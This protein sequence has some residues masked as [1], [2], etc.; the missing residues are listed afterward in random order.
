M[1]HHLLVVRRDVPPERREEYLAGWIT[2]RAA[3]GAAG[4]HAWLFRAPGDPRSLLEFVEWDDD[5]AD[6]TSHAAVA[7]ALAALAS[8]FGGGEERWDEVRPDRS[9]EEAT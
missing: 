6:P 8:A 4:A 7:A 9:Q 5:D 3:V 1:P 2:A